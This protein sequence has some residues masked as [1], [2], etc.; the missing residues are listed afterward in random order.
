MCGFCEVSANIFCRFAYCPYSKV[1]QKW[2]QSRLNYEKNCK[3]S[4]FLLWNTRQ[5]TR[6]RTSRTC[7]AKLLILN[8][9][10][11]KGCPWRS[12]ISL[13]LGELW[14]LYC[15]AICHITLHYIESDF[16]ILWAVAQWHVQLLVELII[17]SSFFLMFFHFYFTRD[18]LTRQKN[19]YPRN[20]HLCLFD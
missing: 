4:A 8:V 9:K 20:A 11:F 19:S 7:I 15:Y 18:Y 6:E 12:D 13:E 3:I 14:D 2:Q 10:I 1:L 17:C 5:R 16:V